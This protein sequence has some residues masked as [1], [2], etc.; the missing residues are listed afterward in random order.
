MTALLRHDDTTEARGQYDDYRLHFGHDDP[1][2][3]EEWL[4][5]YGWEQPLDEPWSESKDAATR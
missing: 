1:L 2:S 3:F 4:R 5:I